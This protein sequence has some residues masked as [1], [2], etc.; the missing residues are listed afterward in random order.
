PD[1][2]AKMLAREHEAF[3]GLFGASHVLLGPD[4]LVEAL[5]QLALA[6]P[7]E[8]VDGFVPASA[9]G[10]DANPEE[11]GLIHDL[12][13]GLVLQPGLRGFL[14]GI[15][16]G[17]AITADGWLKDRTVGPPVLDLAEALF[18]GRLDALLTEALGEDVV[19]SRDRDALV[20]RHKAPWVRP[21]P[22]LTPIPEEVAEAWNGDV[23]ADGLGMNRLLGLE[24]D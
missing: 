20:A 6:M 19:W 11:V 23:P 4:G 10:V 21:Y 7:R 22:H 13:Y 16:A 9:M 17:N 15:E 12:R 14:E 2:V 18:P 8:A 24:A 1:V 3:V 5:Q